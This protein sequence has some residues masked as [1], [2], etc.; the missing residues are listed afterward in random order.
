[1][2]LRPIITLLRLGHDENQLAIWVIPSPISALIS[3]VHELN[4][5]LPMLVTLLGIVILIRLVQ[6]LNAELP[7]FVTLLEIVTFV[8]FMQELNAEIPMLVTLLGIV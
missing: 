8:R 6:E 2:T 5:E 1:M 7:I 4:T 3:L